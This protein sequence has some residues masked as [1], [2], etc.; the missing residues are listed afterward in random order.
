MNK[1]L[2]AFTVA[3]Y[4]YSSLLH[5]EAKW[6]PWSES[7]FVQIENEFGAEAHKRIRHIHQVIQDNYSKPDREKLEIV[8]NT[9]NAVPW[10]SDSRNWDADDYWATPLE[11][12]TKFGGDCED[13]AIGKFVMLRMM[14]IPKQNLELGYVKVRKTGESHMV[15]V[16]L[17]D[18]RSESFV[19]DN[20]DKE[21][22]TGKE[23]SDLLAI[24]LTD[25]DGN[26]ILLNDDHGQRSI[27]SET[28]TSKFEKLNKIKA[29]ILINQEKYKK[30][31]NNRPLF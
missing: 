22:K 1:L 15:L 20:L 7:V 24:Y 23:R 11:T 31:N 30:Y 8:N 14:G 10:I 16:W 28:K 3:F 27:K 5:A 29:Q 21:V 6:Q 17:N 4:L 2:M 13:M 9:L 19:L 18:S 26:F 12:L 25:A